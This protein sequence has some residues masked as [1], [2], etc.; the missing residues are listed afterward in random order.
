MEKPLGYWLQHLHNLLEAQFAG[1][2]A[3]LG[4]NRREWQLV[5]TLSRGARTREA[6]DQALAPF[7]AAEE[8][9]LRDGLARLAA[10]GWIDESGDAVTLT[11]DG[12][13][14]HAE[15]ARRINEARGVV[16]G[17]LSPEQY[18]ETVRILA[19]MAGNVEAALATA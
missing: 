3:D 18:A 14:A 7:W 1:V 19:V 10:R 8:S 5:N 9:G 13:A 6:L 15:L 4:V 12:A 11:D 17:G 2:L 16:L